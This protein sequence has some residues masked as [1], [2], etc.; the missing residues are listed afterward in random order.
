MEE[1]KKSRY[2]FGW[3]YAQTKG[4]RR[5]LVLLA[6]AGIGLA[7]VN[8]QIASILKRFV[9]IAM[10]DSRMTLSENVMAA[11]LILVLEGIFSMV[12]SVS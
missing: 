9:D 8:I 3:I 10:G 12:I 11:L 6:I 2:N 5:Y 1:K 4:N 7:A